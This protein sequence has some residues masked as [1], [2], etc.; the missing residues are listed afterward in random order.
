[1]KT[2]KQERLKE[3]WDKL[4][5]EAEI[6][7]ANILSLTD[8]QFGAEQRKVIYCLRDGKGYRSDL[9]REELIVDEDTENYKEEM[10]SDGAAYYFNQIWDGFDQM[11]E[12]EVFALFEEFTS[13]PECLRVS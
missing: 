2:A 4:P 8:D 10:A 7:G 12:P 13:I 11:T 5:E 6:P 3:V 1:M 9:S